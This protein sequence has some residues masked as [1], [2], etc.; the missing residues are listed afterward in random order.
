MITR[1]IK[2]IIPYQVLIAGILFQ[3]CQLPERSQPWM[4]S[5][6][7][8]QIN[9]VLVADSTFSFQGPM[10]GQ[11][12]HWQKA[13]VFN[14]AAV[15]RNDSI[16]L[17]FRAE[18]N[19]N[20]TLGHRTSRIGLAVS[21]DGMHFTKYPTPVLYPDSSEYMK[22]DWPGGCE[23]PRVVE[24]EDGTYVMLYTSWNY[25]VARL[26]VATSRDLRS[27]TK[28]G[29]VFKDPAHGKFMDMWTKSAS[30]VTKMKNGRLIAA[31]IKNKYWM[32]WGEEFVNLA[33][34]DDLV[35]WEPMLI[36]SG[37]LLH[38]MDTRPGMFDSR[39]TEAG[40]PALLTDAGILFFYNGKNKEDGSGDP[41]VSRGAYCGGQ[42]LFDKNNPS[43]LIDRMDTP[44]ICPSLPH[45]ITGQYKAGTTFTEGLVYYKK[46]WFLYYGTA[47]SMVGLAV[48]DD[49]S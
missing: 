24:R 12:V 1:Y 49:K 21:I 28:Y 48:M 20:A 39:L 35:H 40:P 2:R 38:V 43:K 19:T 36:D 23:D 18:D 31:K 45:E 7:K 33:S 11:T 22:W 10:T 14:P 9:P 17:L 46:K 37:E 44:Y 42:A 6:E 47:D 8:T 16:Y 4:T 27:W 3:A 30:V 34:S 13:D 26:S 41:N 15:V 5:F 29:P 32:Y 25:D